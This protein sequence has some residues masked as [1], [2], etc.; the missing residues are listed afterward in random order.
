MD[1]ATDNIFTV[2]RPT[3]GGKS[4][5]NKIIKNIELLAKLKHGILGYSFLIQ[6]EADGEGVI[7]N[8]NEIFEAAKLA[9][10]YVK[11]D[12]IRNK[13]KDEGVELIDRTADVTDW[14][15]N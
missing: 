7:S 2:L 1:P 3:K 13:L 12:Q 8:V 6:T 4:K 11:A 10:D 5:F 14:I 9:K 15:R